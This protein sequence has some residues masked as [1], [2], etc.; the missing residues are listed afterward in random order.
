MNIFI[1]YLNKAETLYLITSHVN[2][3]MLY[4]PF[5]KLKPSR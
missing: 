2:M 3:N 5:C 1:Q 4:S